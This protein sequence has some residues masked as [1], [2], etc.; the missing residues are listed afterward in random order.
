[1]AG[2]PHAEHG[3]L[4]QTVH[5]ADNPTRGLI[6]NRTFTKHKS[7][8]IPATDENVLLEQLRQATAGE[9]EV[10]DELGCGGMAA[11]YLARDLKLDRK[12]AIKVMS[13]DLPSSH[14]MAERFLLE[15]RTSASL[16]HPHIIPIYA[17]QQTD[18]L[19][20][21]VMKWIQ[22]STLETIA[23]ES[24]PQPFETVQTVLREVGSALSYAHDMGVVHRDVKPA[25]I[26]V[27]QHGKSIVADFGI[28]K[29]GTAQTLTVA[30]ATVGTP[31]YMSP[32]QC[33]GRKLTGAS[34]QY[35]LG[36]VIYE[37]LAGKVPFESESL[38][39]LLWCHV[40]EPPPP[41]L[42][43]RPDC[44]P[45]LASVV[46]RMLEKEV[47]NRWTSLLEAVA[48]IDAAGNESR[49]STVVSPP[50]S[51]APAAPVPTANES[52][53]SV[54]NGD[55]TAG[56][57]VLPAEC[58]LGV[59]ASAQLEATIRDWHGKPIAE[60]SVQW[61]SSDRRAVS[62]SE[63]GVVTGV[64]G[65]TAA[66]TAV[67]NKMIG[68]CVV[69][70]TRVGVANLTL[71]LGKHQTPVGGELRA[72][73]TAVDRFGDLL[74]SRAIRWTSS[75]PEIAAVSVSG[76]IKALKPGV[77]QISVLSEG[78]RASA[79]L[80]V[81]PVCVAR[82]KIE[83]ANTALVPGGQLQLSVCIADAY[84]YALDG[85]EA[86]WSS[87]DPAVVTV[88]KDGI[89]TAHGVGHGVVAAQVGGKRATARVKVTP[90]R[91]D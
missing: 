44:P 4:K 2:D 34:D 69:S 65:G 48:A 9:Y 85:L 61:E 51:R 19:F 8:S 42:D 14:R 76:I 41:I 36:V 53:V 72:Q 28:A 33:A 82:V 68:S 11:V 62:V 43:V 52:D 66:I 90:A 63:D 75:R 23:R 16:E 73:A 25:N 10:L 37:L 74:P 30:G 83:P 70:V 31:T 7:M 6:D 47:D 26:M 89:V 1:M 67:R 56:I 60:Q 17:I 58:S 29:V 54:E 12:V 21:F 27:D 80:T 57:E 18:E 50:T 86:S 32:E 5:S 78:R 13:H 20:Y 88:G 39:G 84:G 49:W 24:G 77:A 87:I 91:L 81:T 15:A 40:N 59:G 46:M 55:R 22:G 35:S 45:I 71:A 64:A 38:I 79:Q 3:A